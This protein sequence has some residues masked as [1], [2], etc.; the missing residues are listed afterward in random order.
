MVS[1]FS[2]FTN[3][4]ICTYNIIN[5]NK[6]INFIFVPAQ[7]I[8]NIYVLLSRDVLYYHI[9]KLVFNGI[10]SKPSRNVYFSNAK[11]WFSQWKNIRF[12]IFNEK[13]KQN[14][15]L[16]WVLTP[17]WSTHGHTRFKSFSDKNGQIKFDTILY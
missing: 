12:G 2:L 17:R 15:R 4:I 3:Y 14:I 11:F 1:T 13:K 9:A 6:Q 8:Q 5:N 7:I 10:D 16:E